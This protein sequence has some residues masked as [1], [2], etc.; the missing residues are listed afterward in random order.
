MPPKPKFLLATLACLLASA[1][2]A[3][4]G[5][6]AL[7][8]DDLPGISLPSEPYVEAANR[9]LLAGLRR[10]RVP[11]IGFVNEGKLNALD[12]R[13]ETA[14]LA[15]WLRSGMDLGN[16]TYSHES[17]N[18]LGADR[19]IADIAQGEPV[20]RALLAKRGKTLRWFRYPNLETGADALTKAKVADWLTGHGYRSAPVTIDADDW[21]FAVP[22]DDA[23]RRGNRTHARAIRD[24]YL[25]HTAAI[26]D[27]ARRGAMA[28]FGRDIAYVM[29][30]HDTRLNAD[31]IDALAALLAARDL[32]FVT[33]ETA[34]RDP[35]YATPD[36][37]VGPDGIEW[38]ERWSKALG[39][40]LP[41]NDYPDV[42]ADIASSYDA[43]ESDRH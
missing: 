25:V 39:R 20:T 26:V 27:W 23:I 38:L 10:H 37:Y 36:T 34:M 12:H 31:S 30:L 28:L 15:S 13:R 9:A 7:T 14:I 19:F 22:Y 11:A 1:V 33:L 8:F 4:A 21:E 24:S 5:E 16:H 2:P 43:L 41:W 40:D 17:L 32:H 29:L 6:V 18:Q 35:A 42:P 3:Q